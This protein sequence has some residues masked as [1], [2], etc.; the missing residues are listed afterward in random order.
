V[1]VHK[2]STSRR[3]RM[4]MEMEMQRDLILQCNAENHRNFAVFCIRIPAIELDL[5]IRFCNH[6]TPFE[7]RCMFSHVYVCPWDSSTA[8]S[9]MAD[10]QRHCP[11]SFHA[12][13]V[14]CSGWLLVGLPDLEGTPVLLHLLHVSLANAGPRSGLNDLSAS[15]KWLARCLVL[16]G[17]SP[18]SSPAASSDSASGASII[19]RMATF[20]VEVTT[21][22]RRVTRS[23]K[24]PHVDR[25]RSGI[26]R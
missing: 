12:S 8:C 26:S 3:S 16:P 1:T 5:S 17:V 20:L 18:P 24:S 9:C 2:N 11:L 6:A 15:T 10:Q 7:L 23:N 21:S 14:R 4:G 19:W 13:F 22:P 25:N